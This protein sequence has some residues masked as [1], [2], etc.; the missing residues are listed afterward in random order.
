MILVR[1]YNDDGELVFG[2]GP[3]GG[4]LHLLFIEP[5]FS[6]GTI[7]TITLEDWDDLRAGWRPPSGN[8]R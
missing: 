3:L 2:P 6:E 7:A 5:M 1:G 8:L 4:S